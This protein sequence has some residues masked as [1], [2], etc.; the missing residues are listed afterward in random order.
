MSYT[1]D[2]K[3]NFGAIPKIKKGL[4]FIQPNH[5][6]ITSLTCSSK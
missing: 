4:D 3:N 5:I 2:N 1:L 6:K